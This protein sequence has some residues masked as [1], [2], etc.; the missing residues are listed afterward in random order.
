M[1]DTT[2]PLIASP[3]SSPT[4]RPVV[5]RTTRDLV[6]VVGPD[7]ATYL[8][9][10]LSQ[11]VAGLAVGDSTWTFVL[12]PQGKVEGW[13]RI[14]RVADDAFEVLVDAGAGEA[15]EA[16]LR[17]FLLRTKADITVT[18]AVPVLAL[19][20]EG[21]ADV[22]AA[23]GPDAWRPAGWPA[24][25]GFDLVLAGAAAEDAVTAGGAGVVE[26]GAA[27]LERCAS[28]PWFRRGGASW[29]P[30]PS[31]PPWASG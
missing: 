22:V 16:R 29:T 15:W 10:Q 26:V 8:Q 6:S 30:T 7:A 18:P 13:G 17:R 21:S 12:A 20:G 3:T 9:G 14:T 1:S 2:P 4:D 24:V 25:D 19:R 5:A 27:E 11:D 23:T 28:E 31:R